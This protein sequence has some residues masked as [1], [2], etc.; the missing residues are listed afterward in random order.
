MT[1]WKN[2]PN[3]NMAEDLSEF[4]KPIPLFVNMSM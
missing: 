1:S 2:A 4:M 3:E